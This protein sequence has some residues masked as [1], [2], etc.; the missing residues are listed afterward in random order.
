MD[1]FKKQIK[2][3]VTIGEKVL[4]LGAGALAL[5]LSILDPRFETL[6]LA[7][8]LIGTLCVIVG[9]APMAWAYI[10]AIWSK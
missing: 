3:L 2:A 5:A 6:K 9:F 1:K 7:M 4:L 8:Q 10:K